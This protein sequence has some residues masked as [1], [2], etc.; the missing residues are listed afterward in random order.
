MGA[1]VGNPVAAHRGTPARG[2]ASGAQRINADHSGRYRVGVVDA[3]APAKERPIEG[4]VG[5]APGVVREGIR[6]VLERGAGEFRVVA[7]VADTPAMV[8]QVREHKPDL[9][10]L[11]LTMPGG[12]SLAAL[13]SCFIAHPT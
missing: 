5:D 9:L 13:P 2:R 4:R 12:S 1:S 8:R 3:G 6:T 11:D 10:I 7:E